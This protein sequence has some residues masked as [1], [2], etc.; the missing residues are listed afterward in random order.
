MKRINNI[1][2]SATLLLFVALIFSTCIK[3]SDDDL[4]ITLE[5]KNAAQ[6][7]SGSQDISGTWTGEWLIPHEFCSGAPMPDND[8][9]QF[10]EDLGAFYG[11]YLDV[12]PD[13]DM[14]I[15]DEDDHGTPIYSTDPEDW[16]SVCASEEIRVPYTAENG[17]LTLRAHGYN[18]IQEW[19]YQICNGV[20]IISTP[21]QDGNKV[22]VGRFTRYVEPD[23]SEDPSEEPGCPTADCSLNYKGITF[24]D[25]VGE[26]LIPHEHYGW[27]SQ[28]HTWNINGQGN[29]DKLSFTLAPPTHNPT[30]GNNAGIFTGNY[31]LYCP[32]DLPEFLTE[33]RDVEISYA[34]EEGGWIYDEC[35]HLIL[36]NE[37]CTQEYK[38]YFS[39]DPQTQQTIMDLYI[40]MPDKCYHAGHFSTF[41]PEIN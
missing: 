27:S 4:T 18:C 16:Y 20:L 26:W 21:D 3:E 17:K 15:V 10:R 36:Y 30:G 37:Y 32:T 12:C 31:L 33:Q 34:Q 28:T 22:V 8:V 5:G 40:E 39:T 41:I 1:L 7:C 25:W 14:F 11:I 24:D 35:N 6:D 38:V 23:P 13:P 2:L 19:D 9:L 29:N